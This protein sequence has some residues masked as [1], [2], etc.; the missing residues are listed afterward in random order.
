[1]T[2]AKQFEISDQALIEASVQGDKKSLEQLIK[3]YQDYIYNISL[4]LF[5]H[6][7]DAL[8]ASQEVLIKVV[9]SLNTFKGNSQFSTWLYRIA[10]NHFLNSPKKKWKN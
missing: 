10:F 2:F 8:D 7:D 6:P 9:T 4:W 3:R 1:M 5:V